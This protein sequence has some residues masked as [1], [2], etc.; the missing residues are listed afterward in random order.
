MDIET[1]IDIVQERELSRFLLHHAL[2]N[3][4]EIINHNKDY[5]PVQQLSGVGSDEK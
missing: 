2:K 4:R 5:T 3:L 1:L